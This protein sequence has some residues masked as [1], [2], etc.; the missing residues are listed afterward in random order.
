MSENPIEL[1][2]AGKEK[3]A[4][5][6]RVLDRFQAETRCESLEVEQLR[7]GL[8]RH[9]EQRCAVKLADAN[10]DGTAP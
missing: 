2:Q 4:R 7:R 8:R 6:Q 1:T 3:L 9:I 5:L 10:M